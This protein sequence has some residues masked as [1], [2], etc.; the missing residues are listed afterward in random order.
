MRS[1]ELMLAINPQLE[2][3]E[4][5]S[6]INKFKK[7]IKEEKGEETKIDK[8]GKRNLAYEIKDF[9]EAYYVVLN[10]NVDEKNVSEL[11]RVI[12]LEEKVIRYLL[13]LLQKTISSTKEV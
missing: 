5:D 3:E 10:F 2:E 13:I 4:L 6:L 1:Y 8:W 7:L 12:K 9:Q 11:E